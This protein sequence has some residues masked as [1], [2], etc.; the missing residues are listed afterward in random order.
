MVGAT[1]SELPADQRASGA[2]HDIAPKLGQWKESSEFVRDQMRSL[3]AVGILDSVVRSKPLTTSTALSSSSSL[4]RIC[5]ASIESDIQDATVVAPNSDAWDSGQVELSKVS[6]EVAATRLSR[7]PEAWLF[8]ETLWGVKFT[9][10]S[11]EAS[12]HQRTRRCKFL[13]RSPSSGKLVFLS[14]LPTQPPNSNLSTLHTL[15]STTLQI[16][17]PP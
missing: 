1:L 7:K 5:I 16:Q 10:R 17:Y 14:Q 11:N 4:Y 9:Y 8:D 13:L 2:S 3:P 15:N 12:D 6:G